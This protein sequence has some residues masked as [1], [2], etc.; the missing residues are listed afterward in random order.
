MLAETRLLDRADRYVG[1]IRTAELVP[2]VGRVL[3]YQGSMVECEGPDCFVGELCEIY[4]S[5]ETRPIR[6]EVIGFKSETVLLMPFGDVQGIRPSSQVLATGRVPQISVGGA[7][8]GRII[9]A[10]GHPLDGKGELHCESNVPLRASAPNAIERHRIDRFFETGV[11]VIDTCTPLGVGQRVGIFAGSGVG[12]STLLGMIAGNSS[13]EINVIALIGERGREVRDFLE[14]HL[15]DALKHS[16][17]IVATA[18]QPALVRVHAAWSAMAIAE[19]FRDQGREVVL[20]LDSLTRLAMAQREIG[21]A[22]GEPPT[23]RGYTPSVFALFPRFLE[24]AGPGR[25]GN[26]SITA[27]FTVLVEGDDLSEP[28]SDHARAIVDGHLVLTRDLA[29]QG[30]FPAMDPLQSVSRVARQVSTPAGMKLAEECIA[31]MAL[32][33]QSKDM[34][35]FGAYKAGSNPRLDK[36]VRVV[37]KLL[38]FFK[39]DVKDVT[40]HEESLSRLAALLS[41]K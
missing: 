13:G 41:E 21:L 6:A 4:G 29:Q 9:D 12:K 26:G 10:F 5:A 15:G 3:S 17:V 22:S 38:S 37:P 31:L 25:N 23:V 8:L 1:A 27:F 16:V 40:A 19:Y 14:E 34:L 39:Q 18:D 24:R 33:E 32:H 35:N 36:A 2:R 20:T 30:Q 7:M 11:R 28:I